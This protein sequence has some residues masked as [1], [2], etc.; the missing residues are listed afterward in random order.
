MRTDNSLSRVLAIYRGIAFGTAALATAALIFGTVA[1]WSMLAARSDAALVLVISTGAYLGI[2]GLLLT[3]HNAL[4]A[5]LATASADRTR[6]LATAHRDELTGAFTRSYFLSLLREDVKH[7]PDVSIGYMQIDM[8]HLKVL[9]DGSGHAAG[10]AALVHLIATVAKVL[11]GAVVGR[12]GGDEFGIAVRSIESKTAL[13]RLGDQI[14]RELGEPIQIA[15]RPVRLSATIGIAAAPNDAQDADQLI[16]KADLALYKGKRSGRHVS[17]VFEDN[18]LVD[19]RH[20]RFIERDLRAAIILN[21]LELHYQP[22]FSSDGETIKS[23]ESLVRWQHSVRGTIMPSDFIPIAEESD[24][25]DKLGDWVVRRA[26]LDFTTLG[27]PAV[28]V[29]VSALQLRRPDFTERFTAILAETGIAGDKLIVEV[30]ETVPMEAGTVELANLTALRN[31]GVR[32]AIDDFGAGHASLG[33]LRGFDFD[34]IKIDRTYVSNL[35]GHRADALIVSA[36]CKIA[37]S[38][39]IEVVAEGIETE[40][41]MRFLRRSGCTAMQGY[42]LGRPQPL[43]LLR[44][45]QPELASAA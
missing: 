30:T 9:N 44:Q 39:Q 27:A 3:G 23:Y 37:R 2:L 17:V 6:M 21:E 10:D 22:V 20:K 14:L 15:G 19:E 42:L 11:P 34:I 8:D 33:Y 38:L 1:A 13:K 32:V 24:L 31:I 28:G 25:I 18:M 5:R 36:I 4:R 40:A 43:R 16:T 7:E 29:N 41:Q 26:C 12:L 45:A 35:P